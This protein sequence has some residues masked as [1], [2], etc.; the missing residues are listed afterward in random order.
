MHHLEQRIG[1]AQGGD[2]IDDAQACP[3]K[4]AA[5]IRHR[6]VRIAV[7]ACSIS[8]PDRIAPSRVLSEG[9]AHA[10]GPFACRLLRG[11]DCTKY[12]LVSCMYQTW[13][14][15]VK[16]SSCRWRQNHFAATYNL[17]GYRVE[18]TG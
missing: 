17:Q 5:Q 4:D 10:A 12:Y 15:F 14:Q 7:L 16:L 3:D 6:A 2:S 9:F 13:H 1:I 8:S 18:T 11:C